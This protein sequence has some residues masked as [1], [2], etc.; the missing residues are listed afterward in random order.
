M[1]RRGRT[2]SLSPKT[3]FPR[4]GDSLDVEG[5][6]EVYTCL[7]QNNV[8]FRGVTVRYSLLA[9]TSPDWDDAVVFCT[10]HDDGDMAL[11][12][13]LKSVKAITRPRSKGEGSIRYEWDRSTRT[14]LQAED[15]D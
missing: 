7:R 9:A 11:H 14:W 2:G 3:Y 10:Y 1:A 15:E 8:V 5:S 13:L 12:E 4:T 6:N